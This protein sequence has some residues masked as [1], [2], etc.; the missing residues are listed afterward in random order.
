MA[1]HP[2]RRSSGRF[3]LRL[4]PDLH[5][6]LQAAA[7]AQGLSLN[8]Y[9]VRRLSGPAPGVSVSAGAI[10]ALARA[11]DVFG[12]D[13]VG[14]MMYGSWARGDV[15]DRSDID[16]LV[17]VERTTRLTRAL[18][19]RWDEAPVAW[20]GRTVDPHFVHLPAGEE[21][22]GGAWCEAAVDGA[23]L[24]ERDDRISDRLRQVRRHI[25]EGRLVRRTAHGQPYWTVAA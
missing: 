10:D 6:S 21:P 23:V 24:F 9:C 8:E 4:P 20:S 7:R 13:L 1:S 22:A 12:A 14:V 5:A 19:R 2:P 3:L 17:V 25:A 16:L 18:Y 15:T 11:V